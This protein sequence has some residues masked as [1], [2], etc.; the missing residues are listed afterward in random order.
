[1]EEIVDKLRRARKIFISPEHFFEKAEEKKLFSSLEK[2][3]TIT[4][5]A[6][7]SFGVLIY[8]IMRD[9]CKYFCLFKSDK[10]I[11]VCCPITFVGKNTFLIKTIYSANEEQIKI[12]KKAMMIRKQ[13][14][15]NK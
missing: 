5:K 1:M 9:D 12:Y 15:L 6:I 11:I 3:D 10:D 4:K 2:A 13:N 7:K 8:P 14:R